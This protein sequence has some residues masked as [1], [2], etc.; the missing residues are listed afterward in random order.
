MAPVKD[1]DGYI[2]DYG[3]VLVH[4]QAEAEQARMAQVA[5]IPTEPF[6]E[7]YWGTRLDYDKGLM[8]GA[9]YWSGIGRA[10][11]KVLAPNVVEQL[12]EIDSTTWMNFDEPMWTWME[13]LRGAGKR[14]A[15]LSNM[16][17]DLGETIKARTDRM[18]RFDFVT[19][20]YEVK[21][22]K[23]E[24]LIYEHCLEGIA[25]DPARTV[26]F[27]DRIANIHGAEM[28]GI[29]A[30]QFLNRDEVLGQFRSK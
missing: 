21:S 15:I 10:A 27:D 8:S 20:S 5:G 16:P 25:T 1:F 3:G 24:P 13:E 2:F 28:L 26:F 7:L 4:H 11:G 6:S 23:P 17:A 29:Q 19:L 9:E 30:V 12:T 18:K 22:V 14:I